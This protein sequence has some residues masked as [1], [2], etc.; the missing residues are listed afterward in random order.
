[1]DASVRLLCF[2]ET[3]EVDN[4]PLQKEFDHAI[5]TRIIGEPQDIVIDRS[6][7]L[8]WYIHHNICK[9]FQE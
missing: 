6:G 5:H 9:N 1:M 4:L 7:F 2:T 8:L 3:L